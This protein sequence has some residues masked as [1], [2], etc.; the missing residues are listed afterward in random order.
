M[1]TG[2]I[3]NEPSQ[4]NYKR[5]TV[6]VTQTQFMK[7]GFLSRDYI[8][9]YVETDIPGMAEKQRCPRRVED[10]YCLRRLLLK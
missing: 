2:R 3:D 8:L 4:L 5:V 9:Y 6:K 1:P 7:G 10:F